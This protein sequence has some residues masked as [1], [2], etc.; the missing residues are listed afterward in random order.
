[1]PV[2]I[3]PKISVNLIWITNLKHLPVLI[4]ANFKSMKCSVSTEL[5]PSLLLSIIDVV[6]INVLRLFNSYRQ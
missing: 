4:L 5:S 1:M 6:I 3:F 2:P